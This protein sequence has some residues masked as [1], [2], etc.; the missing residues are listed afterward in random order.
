MAGT[1]KRHSLTS[2]HGGPGRQPGGSTNVGTE[3]RV[4]ELLQPWVHDADHAV[5]RLVDGLVTAGSVMAGA[6]LISRRASPML[7]PFSVLGLL[8]AGVGLLMWQRLLARRHPQR[9]WVGVARELVRAF[10]VTLPGA[11]PASRAQARPLG[12]LG[13]PCR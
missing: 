7:G 12:A 2:A 4:A 8:C 10:P 6:E 11:R 1:I 5:D 3:V 9:S 13:G